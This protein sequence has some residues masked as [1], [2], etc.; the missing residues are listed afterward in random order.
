MSRNA[1]SRPNPT[2]RIYMVSRARAQ[3]SRKGNKNSGNF[4]FAKVTNMSVSG[5]PRER[6]PDKAAGCLHSAVTSDSYATVSA[7]TFLIPERGNGTS[8]MTVLSH[9]LKRLMVRRVSLYDFV[10]VFLP[11]VC[12]NPCIVS[13]QAGDTTSEMWQQSLHHEKRYLPLKNID[14][15]V[16]L[17]R[18]PET[19]NIVMHVISSSTHAGHVREEGNLRLQNLKRVPLQIHKRGPPGLLM[20]D[21]GRHSK[22]VCQLLAPLVP[23]LGC[24]SLKRAEM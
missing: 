19:L 5:V 4:L 23:N 22:A 13:H 12:N 21:S 16:T 7:C 14:L 20:K 10:P 17:V 15:L 9:R 24:Q 2:Y 1:Y 11:D 3:W 6:T 8:C 18:R